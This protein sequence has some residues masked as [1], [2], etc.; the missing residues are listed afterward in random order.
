MAN[1]S[2]N[3]KLE[4]VLEAM[5]DF[6]TEES[7]ENLQLLV[8]LP[9]AD[10]YKYI[11]FVRDTLDAQIYEAI[12]LTIHAHEDKIGVLQNYF[13]YGEEFNL[14]LDLAAGRPATPINEEIEK[15][16]E[17]YDLHITLQFNLFHAIEKTIEKTNELNNNIK[18]TPDIIFVIDN[19]IN[20]STSHIKH[21][22]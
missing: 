17:N 19:I 14:A 2:I 5:D 21:L 8:K 11:N 16:K 4:A 10:C 6:L 20:F 7:K 1:N 3:R 15:Y 9:R 13:D 22:K 18:L 12:S